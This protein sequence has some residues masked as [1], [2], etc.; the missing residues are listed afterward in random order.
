[1]KQSVN[2]KKLSMKEY[3]LLG[4]DLYQQVLDIFEK[5]SI[6]KEIDSLQF[7]NLINSVCG[8]LIINNIMADHQGL[9]VSLNLFDEISTQLRNNIRSV[10][11][12]DKEKM[13]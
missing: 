10:Y 6:E 5:E 2:G 11:F 9:K 3:I 8:T 7:F 4:E 12:A 1:M 13:Q